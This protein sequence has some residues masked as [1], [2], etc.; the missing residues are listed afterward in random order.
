MANATSAYLQLGESTLWIAE[1]LTGMA[2]AAPSA[3]GRWPDGPQDIAADCDREPD[4]SAEH[5]PKHD[6]AT[7][8]P[9]RIGVESVLPGEGWWAT[10]YGRFLGATYDEDMWVRGSRSWGPSSRS[11][12][13][14]LPRK[15]PG[16]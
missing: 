13:T 1:R 3:S 12:T 7:S 5:E 2:T 4:G 10:I 11:F 16:V 9:F 6:V 8:T 14:R 15:N